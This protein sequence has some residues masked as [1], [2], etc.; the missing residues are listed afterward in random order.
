L[1]RNAGYPDDPSMHGIIA[2]LWS[3]LSGAGRFISRVGTGILVDCIGFNPT[4]AIM[5]TLQLAIVTNLKVSIFF[6]T[7]GFT[8]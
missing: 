1:I 6:Q 4:A 8:F 5:T 7:N 3:S 2:G